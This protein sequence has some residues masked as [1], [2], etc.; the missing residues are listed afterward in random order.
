MADSSQTRFGA[1]KSEARDVR[2]ATV[3]RSPGLRPR[4]LELRFPKAAST[5]STTFWGVLVETERL[6]LRDW[7]ASDEAPF[8]AMNADPEV[9]RY[10]RG[11]MSRADSDE[12]L[13]RIRGHW[14]QHGYGLYAVE[15][16]ESGAFAGFVGLAIPSFL[17]EVLPAV[18]VGWRLVRD[19]WGKGYATE[20]ARASL[21]HGFGELGLRRII[22][23]IDPRNIA[24]VR[25]AQRLEMTR[26]RDRIHPV[27]RARLA[28]YAKN[29]EDAGSQ[30]RG[31]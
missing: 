9:T 10:L 5:A 26:G 4:A 24:S 25:V 28:V 20:G 27:T 30:R 1:A 8:A 3:L 12:L 14:Q 2:L 16:K 11:P 13:A 29:A 6:L 23:I 21:A 17:P 22:S 31:S 7:R 19:H 18:E 15:V